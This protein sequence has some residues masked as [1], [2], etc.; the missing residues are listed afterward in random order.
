MTET[1]FSPLALGELALPNRIVM[2]PL[3]RC[4][5]DADNAPHQLHALYYAQRASAGLIVSE[6]SQIV[7]EGQGYPATPGIH[8]S[9]QI[10]GWRQVTACV[11]AAGGRMFLQLW[12]VGRVSHPCYQPDGKLPVAPS[13]LAPSG[14]VGTPSG[15]QPFVI[16]RAL[17]IGELPAIAAA[18]AQ[19][20]RNAMQAGFDGVEIHAANGYLLDQFLR[21]A[22]NQR[23]DG[24]GGSV[25]NRM[26][27]LNEVVDAV[28]AVVGKD[29]VGVRISPENSFNDMRDSDPQFL[30]DAV[31]AELAGRIGYLHVV[32]GEDRLNRSSNFDYSALRRLFG[33][34]YVA[35]CHYTAT[36][37]ASAVADGRA[38]LV[39]FG[40]A[41]IA[42]PDLVTR[43]QLGLALNAPD[44]EHFYG[45]DWRGYT[46]YPLASR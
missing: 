2:A 41:Y 26:R 42:N 3:T 27:L 20:T 12:H 24:Y 25:D 38:D 33:G 37:A 28:T 35:A 6:A 14:M 21:D 4:R 13:A 8:S 23:Q 17:E 18:Y 40:R 43:L 29:K 15:P 30:F 31:A 45:G 9:E 10:R 44:S 5:A 34:V 22:S 39:A 11:H 32:E 16:P 36:R 1:L 46:D 19:A 7:P